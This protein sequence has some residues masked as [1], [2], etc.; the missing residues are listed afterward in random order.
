MFRHLCTVIREFYT[1]DQLTKNINRGLCM[2]PE[3]RTA[4]Q[5]TVTSNI[6]HCVTEQRLNT[7]LVYFN[8]FIEL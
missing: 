5:E 1:P 3:V 6:I 4:A 2:Q 7:I 8:N